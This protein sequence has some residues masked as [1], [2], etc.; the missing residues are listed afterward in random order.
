MANDNENNTVEQ[1]CEVVGGLCSPE[2]GSFETIDGERVYATSLADRI[3]T[4]HK[5]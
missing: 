5:R 4:A 3:L 1:L 2:D